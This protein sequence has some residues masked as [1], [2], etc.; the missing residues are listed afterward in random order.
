MRLILLC[1]ALVICTASVPDVYASE[2]KGDVF[3][4][5]KK[6]MPELKLLSEEDFRKA[7]RPIKKK[8]YGQDVLE[9]TIRIPKGWT[10]REDESSSNFMLSEKLFMKLSVFY[11]KP[12]PN[13]R[14]RI[15]VGA[16]NFEGD[17]TA[18]QWYLDYIIKEG[19][20]TEGLITHNENRVESL[21]IY[22][23]ENYTYYVRTAVVFNGDK[24]VTVKYFIPVHYIREQAPMQEQVIKSFKLVNDV[25]R[26]PVDMSLYRFLDI[27]ELR[28]PSSWK[29]Y[30][31][32]L[33]TVDRMDVSLLN[34]REVEVAGKSR[35]H[36]SVDTE[37]KLEVSLVAASPYET[38]IDE[39]G[40]YRQKIE[41][42]GM[43][44]GDKLEVKSDYTY[45]D[46]MDFAITEVYESV[47]STN[48]LSEYEL[49]FTVGVGGN[50]YYFFTLFTPSRNDKFGIW[51]RNTQSYKNIMANFTPMSGAFLE[52]DY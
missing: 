36:S 34:I 10:E 9:Y 15:E 39:I 3:T 24:I 45:S 42:N 40:K 48:N 13:G 27:A 49:W 28:Y 19:Y 46:N 30:S 16:L 33:R 47:D 12:T 18:E 52:R 6:P 7:T 2:G 5:F 41:A 4:R 8:P 26:T 21:I 29:V 20:T 44:I 50:Y 22:V 35:K 51:A 1:V 11:G 31:K 32:P 25:E 14:S 17:L 23:G 43:L 37:G 38:L